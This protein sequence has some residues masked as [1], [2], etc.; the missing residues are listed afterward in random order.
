MKEKMIN[1]GRRRFIS[2][3]VPLGM[4]TCLGCKGLLAFPK[5]ATLRS[6]SDQENKFA[7][8]PGMTT[9]DSYRF[10]YGT[11]IPI[12]QFLAGDMGRDKLIRQL[13]AAAAASA[14][15]FFTAMAR[16]L[17]KRDMI[18]FAGLMDGIMDTAP[19]NKAFTYETIEKSEKVCEF[20]FSQCL[21][22]RIWLEMKAADLGHAL[23]CSPSD[24]MVK[25]FNPIAKAT[26]IK[27]ILRGDSVCIERF[28]L[29]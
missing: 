13:E 3:T 18:A 26:S 5:N 7:E 20:K 25:A 2:R 22:A 10:F 15:Q 24:A 12:L 23:E 16:D 4:L 21:P 14:A 27:N 6:S 11:F 17:P 29:V 28:E 9:E 1:P 8:N 19:Y